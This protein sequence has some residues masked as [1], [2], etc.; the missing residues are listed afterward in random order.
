MPLDFDPPL[1]NSA[2]LWATSYEDL[3]SLYFSKST[4]AVTTRTSLVGGFDHDPLIHQ[5]CFV[6]PE[7]RSEFQDGPGASAPFK[8]RSVTSLNTYGYSPYPLSL[9]LEWSAKIISES[10]DSSP[11]ANLKPIIISVTGTSADIAQAYSDT[12]STLRQIHCQGHTRARLLLEVNLS[13]PNIANKPPPAYSASLLSEYLDAVRVAQSSPDMNSAWLAVPVGIKTPPYTYST[14]FTEL[15]SA[16]L[17]SCSLCGIAPIDGTL[18]CPLSFITATNTLGSSLLLAPSRI[19]HPSENSRSYD[20]MLAS[21]SGTGIGGLAGNALHPLAL[22][23]VATIRRMLDEH[24]KLRDVEIIGVGGINDSAG[25]ERMRSAGAAAVGVG[26]A[27]GSEG[28]GIFRM[29]LEKAGV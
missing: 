6:T 12:A 5:H 2:S 27:L 3:K 22:G 11:T 1:L 8:S 14:Q 10:G 19:L 9:Y 25:F 15:I 18:R 7:D 29:I 24:V 26:T 21:A 16:M 28:A 4:G 17:A 20:P 23:N 13:C